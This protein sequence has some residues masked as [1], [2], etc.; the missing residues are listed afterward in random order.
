VP[1]ELSGEEADWVMSLMRA[2]EADA[3]AG[4]TRITLMADD[5]AMLWR[6]H[7]AGTPTPEELGLSEDLCR[8]LWAWLRHWEDNDIEDHGAWVAEGDVLAQAIA[9]E[10]GPTTIVDFKR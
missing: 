2:R 1:E 7:N 3:A 5:G 6:A 4:V 8:R 9:D 10:L